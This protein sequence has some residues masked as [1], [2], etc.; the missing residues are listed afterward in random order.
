MSEI[1]PA[2]IHFGLGCSIGHEPLDVRKFSSFSHEDPP[3]SHGKSNREPNPDVES[4]MF[5]NR[6]DR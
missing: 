3:S 4:A 6:H 1:T 5:G 2:T